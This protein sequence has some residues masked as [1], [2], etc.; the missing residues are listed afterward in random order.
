MFEI[1]TPVRTLSVQYRD[2]KTTFVWYARRVPD[3]QM[4]RAAGQVGWACLAGL[5]RMCVYCT[6]TVISN[7]HSTSSSELR[8]VQTSSIRTI[9]HCSTRSAAPSQAWARTL[10]GHLHRG[11]LTQ[12]T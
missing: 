5:I 12:L 10:T 1:R 11:S 7:V 9:A 4:P 8:D 6:V 3:S 2:I